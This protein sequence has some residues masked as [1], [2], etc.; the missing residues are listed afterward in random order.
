MN[1]DIGLIKNDGCGGCSSNGGTPSALWLLGLALV[2]L[3]RR[4]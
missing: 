2:G 3:R 1:Q 4:R